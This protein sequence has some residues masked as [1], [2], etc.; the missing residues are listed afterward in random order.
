MRAADQAHASLASSPLQACTPADGRWTSEPLLCLYR[1]GV[2]HDRLEEARARL[3]ALGGGQPDHPWPTLVLAFATQSDDETRAIGFYEL[4]ADGFLR[5]GD[6]EGEVLARH[7]LRNAY[8]RRGDATTAARHVELARAAAGR[9]KQPLVS[10]RAGVLEASHLIES[11]GDLER[12][13]RAL[14]S[15]ERMAFPSGPIGLRRTILFNLA[16]AHMN[17]GRF[18]EAIDAL[19]RH[20][21]LRKEDG[22]PA[23]A[24]MV[25]FNLLNARLTRNEVLPRPGARDRLIAEAREVLDLVRPFQ[26]PAVEARVHRVLADLLRSTDPDE[27]AVHLE[28]CLALEAS[29]GQPEIRAACYWSISLNDAA[30]DPT[31][32]EQLSRKAL[33]TLAANPDGPM[34]AFAWRA[35]LRLAWLTMGQDEAVRASLEALGAIERLRANQPD[36]DTRAALFSNWTSDYYWLVGRLLGASPPRVAQA[37]E[38]GERLR[39]RVLLERLS[40]SGAPGSRSGDATAALTAFATLPAVQQTLAPDEALL[41]FT[42]APWTDV[43]GDFG[44]GGWTITLA[45]DSVAVHRLPA[46][47]DLH[48]QVPALTGLLRAREAPTDRWERAASALGA[49]LVGQATAHLS[50]DITRLV[51]VS[52]G[53]LHRLPF[54]VLRPRADRPRLG[55]RFELTLVPSAT[56]WLHLRRLSPPQ[57]SSR[58]V[59]LADP[60]L[61][62]VTPVDGVR[63]E[64]LP[65]A[66]REAR[67]IARMMG[68]GTD[69]VRE[70][71]EA[72]ERLLKQAPVD[73]AIVHLAA[74]ARVD[75]TFPDRS[76]VF[77]APGDAAE[78]GWLHPHE[79]AAL[80]LPGRIVVLSACESAEGFLLSGEGPLSLARAFF[81][82]GATA[83]VATRWPLRD[84]DAAF[85]MARFYRA[86][87]TGKRVAAAVRQARRDAIDAGRPAAAWAGLV[88]L[89]DGGRSPIVATHARRASPGAIT[90]ALMTTIVSGVV[91]GALLLALVR[92]R[93]SMG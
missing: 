80:D 31:R 44:G 3:R 22:A 56:L 76:A 2:Q 6:A 78:D 27:A 14:Q 58:A 8:W 49:A 66:R 74:H 83:V 35:R 67:A 62:T 47:L 90:S 59:V 82:A 15:A 57:T 12:A 70:G 65:W 55:D 93:Q 11:G 17:L 10:A 50:P 7:N 32:A 60:E 4:A 79:I 37:F 88:L 45:R 71:P 24:P 86:L 18:D 28:R 29:L 9:S 85:L 92:R 16:S 72:S 46:S 64:P 52:D 43:Y 53:P 39:T 23:D 5:R 38:I 69:G 25:L 87:G 91:L 41:W 33:D 36:E 34:Q 48:S 75:E 77:L 26:R 20:R 81:A 40:R 21:A 19:E 51:I 89:G 42:I 1:T 84:D 68:L 13:S 54:D 30:R 63:L 61:T 73:A